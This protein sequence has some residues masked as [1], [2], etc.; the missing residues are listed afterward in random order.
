MVW[1]PPVVPSSMLALVC[2]GHLS[3][4][5]ALREDTV[6]S[7][8]RSDVPGAPPHVSS[9]QAEVFLSHAGGNSFV[10]VLRNTSANG[11]LYLPTDGS[12]V[13][14]RNDAARH[15][16]PG[17]VFALCAADPELARVVFAEQAPTVVSIDLV[18]ESPPAKRRKSTAETPTLS[19]EPR[20]GRPV[21]LLLSGIIGSGKST[22]ASQLSSSSLSRWQHVCQDT[23]RDGKPGSRADVL[24]AALSGLRSGSHVCVDRIHLSVEQRSPFCQLATILGCQLHALELAIPFEVCVERIMKRTGHPHGV[25]GPSGVAIAHRWRGAKDNVSPSSAK[26]PFQQV[27]KCRNDCEVAATVQRYASLPPPTEPVLAFAQPTAKSKLEEAIKTAAQALRTHPAPGPQ[28]PP[29]ARSAAGPAPSRAGPFGGGGG[30][31]SSG[32]CRMADAPNAAEPG[33]V[34]SVTPLLVRAR[35][36]FPKA[37]SH[38]LLISREPGLNTLAQLQPRHEALLVAMQAEAERHLNEARASGDASLAGIPFAVGFHAVPSM[39]RLHCHVISGDYHSDALKNRK[40]WQSFH[41][42]AFFLP[43]KA[44]LAQLRSSGRVRV[45]TAAAEACLSAPMRCHRCGAQCSTMPALKKHIEAC[46]AP[47]PPGAAL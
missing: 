17:D 43:L 20:G 16:Q 9:R 34:L 29:P 3:R 36:K 1:T 4:S 10:P 5:I 33:V 6:T 39:Q 14:L 8:G 15:L 26:E 30:D 25:E 40:H 38:V 46:S 42:P 35:D 21:L 47:V 11:T 23:V 2:K 13:L 28:L 37:R 31:W 32:L 41:H 12:R 22:C 27:V 45:D 24:Q 7:L 19:M 44:V 18:E